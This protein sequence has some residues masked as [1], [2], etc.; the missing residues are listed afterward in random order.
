MLIYSC[1]LSLF[2]PWLHWLIILAKIYWFWHIAIGWESV[3]H[4][5]TIAQ[6]VT[7]SD[8]ADTCSRR[9]DHQ[10]TA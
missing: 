4:L 8:L 2:K 5:P 7:Q 9:R 1:R 3:D 10:A 6:L